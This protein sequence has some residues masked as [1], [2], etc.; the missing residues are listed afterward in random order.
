MRNFMQNLHD[1]LPVPPP[2]VEK[3]TEAPTDTELLSTE[4]IQPLA[5]QDPP[6][7]SDIRQLIREE[8]SINVCE[9]QK[10]NMEKK[11]LELVEICHHKQFLCMHDNEQEVKNIEEQPAEHRNHAKKS[12]QNFRVIYKSP[13]SLKHTSQISS[14]H[15]VAPILST[16]ERENSLSMGH[17]ESV[18][19]I[20]YVDALLP[21]PKITS[22][23]EEN[24]VHQEEEDIDL[25]DIQDIVL[26]KK[27]FSINHLIANI[28]SLKDKPT[29][30]CVFNSSTSISIFEES[31]ESLL[32][33]FSP[34]FET[35]CDHTKEMRSGNTTTH[36]NYSIPEYDS[37]HFEIE[38]DQEKLFSAAMNDISD[39]SS[40]ESLLEE[41][42]LF[43]TTDHS[44][45]PGIENFYD[46]EGD[47][48]FL[49]ALLINDFIPFS[50]NES[51]DFENDPSIPRPPLKP[52]D[53]ETN[54]EVISAV[55]EN[56]NEPNESF[57]PGGEIFVSTNDEDVDY[58]PFMFFIQIFLPY[59]IHPEI[60]PLFLSAESE[61]T[62]FDPGISDLNQWIISQRLKFS[63]VG[64]FVRFP[65]SSYPLIDSS[66]G[67]FISFDLYCL[68]VIF[69]PLCSNCKH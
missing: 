60:S 38:P 65:R 27:L 56:I 28:E 52:P 3:E 68:A 29:P 49:E 48:H 34:E 46:P 6:H 14:V 24:V 36:A 50:V 54:P 66:L 20:E 41:V 44:I 4:D 17:D 8:C 43:L 67:K 11:M 16:K 58:F 32:D 13:I 42:N 39:N 35:F 30:V 53:E 62:V 37:F 9:E 45:P 23:E 2:G 26:R 59:L 18:E 5:V 10:Q 22:V 51:F 64:I 55:M 57:D 63:C 12:L 25:E 40:N 21:D 19:D 31:D 1:G 33:N 15:V 61:D 7:D 69:P 47:I